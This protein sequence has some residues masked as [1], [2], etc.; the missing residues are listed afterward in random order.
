M[1]NQLIAYYIHI[2]LLALDVIAFISNQRQ[3]LFPKSLPQFWIKLIFSE[4]A[5]IQKNIFKGGGGF[6]VY[7]SFL[8]GRTRQGKS[9]AYFW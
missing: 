9:E 2:T 8:E 5:R 3:K 4:H 1:N 7:L 6:E